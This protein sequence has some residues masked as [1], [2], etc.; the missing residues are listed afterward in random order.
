MSYLSFYRK[1]RPQ[2]FEEVVG[3]EH[4]VKT[5]TNA[6]ELDRVSHAYLFCGPRGTGKT[7]MAKLLAKAI[8]C[9]DG[10][11]S[12]PCG[13]CDSCRGIVAGKLQLT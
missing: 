11:T 3:Q 6:I 5:I 9:V 13:V 1:Y 12:R 7:T 4:I 8:N 2:R 10:P